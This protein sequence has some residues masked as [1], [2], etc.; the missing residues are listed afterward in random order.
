MENYCLIREAEIYLKSMYDKYGST[1]AYV[2][3]I[4]DYI[5]AEL[6]DFIHGQPTTIHG[7]PTTSIKCPIIGVEVNNGHYMIEN[8][9][10]TRTILRLILD[11]S[12]QIIEGEIVEV[13]SCDFKGIIYQEVE[14]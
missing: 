2:V 6:K 5:T 9:K 8:T 14:C 4:D 13:S 7:Q 10:N 11:K 3:H 12:E 1:I